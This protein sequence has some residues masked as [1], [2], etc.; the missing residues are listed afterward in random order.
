[1]NLQSFDRDRQFRS[2][3]VCRARNTSAGISL[4]TRGGHRMLFIVF[5]PYIFV[6]MSHKSVRQ[7]YNKFISLINLQP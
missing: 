2:G 4:R 6:V 7:L 5:S 3:R 1:M